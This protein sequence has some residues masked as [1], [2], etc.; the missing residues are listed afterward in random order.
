[1]IDIVADEK[2]PEKKKKPAKKMIRRTGFRERIKRA[3]RREAAV[4][5]RK[6]VAPMVMLSIGLGLFALLAGLRG[7]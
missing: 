2:K 3:I 6:A 5:A 1:M 4:G 7:R